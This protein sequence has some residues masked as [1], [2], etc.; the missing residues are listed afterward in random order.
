MAGIGCQERLEL[1]MTLVLL[2][3]VDQRHT[4]GL[5]EE[6]YCSRAFGMPWTESNEHL[7]GRQYDN[8]AASVQRSR[9]SNPGRWEFR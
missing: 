7:H 3:R 8:R 4:A 6:L 1:F 5:H 9:A 2:R